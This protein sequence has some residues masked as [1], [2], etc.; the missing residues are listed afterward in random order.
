MHA[1]IGSD[2]EADLNPNAGVA[3]AENRIG[4]GEGFGW[5]S[6]P[7]ARTSAGVRHVG[8][9]GV[10]HGCAPQLPLADTEGREPGNAGGRKGGGREDEAGEN[11]RP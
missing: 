10:P 11:Q 8:E 3:V 5:L 6:L 7:A 1:P 4:C 9:F 2:D